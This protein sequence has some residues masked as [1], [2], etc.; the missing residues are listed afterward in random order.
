MSVINR[1]T[2]MERVGDSPELLLELIDLFMEIGPGMLDDI[3]DSI[4]R[5]S[6]EDLQR[7]AH[8]FKGSVGNF[9]AQNVFQA[10]LTLETMGRNMEISGAQDAV[11]LLEKE[12]NILTEELNAIK[13]EFSSP[14]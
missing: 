8:T 10:A 14:Q 12:M 13:G 4:R 3:K 5:G 6:A 2:L 11:N 1:E 9:A 7:S